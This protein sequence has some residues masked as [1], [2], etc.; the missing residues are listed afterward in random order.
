MYIVFRL[1]LIL[2]CLATPL[3][4]IFP[5]YHGCQFYW[6]GKLEKT[7]DLSQVTDKPYHIMVYTS[8]WSRFELTTSVVIGIDYMASCKANY[9]TITATMAPCMYSG[10]PDFSRSNVNA[11]DTFYTSIAF[12]YWTFQTIKHWLRIEI[13]KA[14]YHNNLFRIINE[15]KL[16]L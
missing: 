5:L 15:Y 10:R 1:G 14:K 8:P 2:W 7:S 12:L 11:M 13:A 4:T 6:W 9:H 3:S 16:A